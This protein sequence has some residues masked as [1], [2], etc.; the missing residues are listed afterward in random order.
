MEKWWRR[1]TAAIPRSNSNL[2]PISGMSNVMTLDDMTVEG[3]SNISLK[4]RLE[5][6]LNKSKLM[7]KIGTVNCDKKQ[8]SV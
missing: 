3:I 5:G 8:Y 2:L 6:S 7:M 4:T 1:A